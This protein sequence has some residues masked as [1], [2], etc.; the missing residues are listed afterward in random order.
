MAE[1]RPRDTTDKIEE[2]PESKKQQ[3]EKGQI[4]KEQMEK[5]QMEKEEADVWI[6]LKV[7]ELSRTFNVPV[8]RHGF[9]LFANTF[10]KTLTATYRDKPILYTHKVNS[11]SEVSGYSQAIFQLSDYLVALA[12][13][14]NTQVPLCNVPDVIVSLVDLLIGLDCLYL[15]DGTYKP[16]SKTGDIETEQTMF[17]RRQTHILAK[18]FVDHKVNIESLFVHNG[19]IDKLL[20]FLGDVAGELAGCHL[21]PTNIL[22]GLCTTSRL[23]Q[24]AGRAIGKHYAD[25]KMPGPSRISP[26]LGLSIKYFE[27][28]GLLN[29]D[30]APL[31]L[32]KIQNYI[33]LMAVDEIVGNQITKIGWG[34]GQYRIASAADYVGEVLADGVLKR[35]FNWNGY[36]GYEMLPVFPNIYLVKF[37]GCTKCINGSS[38]W[39]TVD[40]R[41]IC[42]ACHDVLHFN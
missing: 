13:D 42:G 17:W 14:K 26:N 7:P 39:L 2:T 3:M 19:S 22:V 29:K 35:T 16:K 9:N 12:T 37:M 28:L 33:L 5:E 25:T 40:H 20:L 10:G 34:D 30:G 8:R 4:E 1:K 32:S 27:D 18:A 38:Y 36:L 15:I 11:V 31:S 6:S 41:P 23:R 24:Y 21:N